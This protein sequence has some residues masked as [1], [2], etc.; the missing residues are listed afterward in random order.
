MDLLLMTPYLR[1]NLDARSDTFAEDGGEVEVRLE[2]DNVGLTPANNTTVTVEARRGP[3]LV[4][5]TS[6]TLDI[7]AGTLGEVRLR[8]DLGEG[9]YA[10]RTIVEYPKRLQENATVERMLLER[11][12]VAVQGTLLGSSGGWGIGLLLLLVALGAAV[13]YW[14]YRGGRWRPGMVYGRLMARARPRP[15][16]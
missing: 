4:G 11:H 9:T 7:P 12:E 1:A 6:T 5:T 10:L 15:G 14:A 13:L 8:M 3:D 2:L 16:A